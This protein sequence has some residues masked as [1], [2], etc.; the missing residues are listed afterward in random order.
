MFVQSNDL[1]YAPSGNG[2]A[3]WTS[4]GNPLSGDIT[5]MIQLWDAGTEIDQTPG[6]GGDQAPRQSG[7]NTGAA[8]PNN[9]VREV[10]DTRVPAVD[11]V[12]RVTIT[13]EG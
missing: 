6:V 8:D 1:F 5:N 2:I 3:L 12:I 10:N 11:R 9:T 7:P 4:G 13:P